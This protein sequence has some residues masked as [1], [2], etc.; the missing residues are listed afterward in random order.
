MEE[1]NS[2][3]SLT[4]PEWTAR[5][6]I[7]E[8]RTLQ[9][10]YPLLITYIKYCVG[11]RIVTLLDPM[12]NLGQS[13][14]RGASCLL[15]LFLHSSSSSTQIWEAPSRIKRP[16]PCMISAVK[17]FGIGSHYA[18]GLHQR[19]HLNSYTLRVRLQDSVSC[20]G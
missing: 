15:K 2:S 6:Y 5:C 13:S 17:V 3:E 16:S 9:I 4:D 8:Y 1:T 19:P 11:E 18:T 10:L 12:Q 20:Q 7:P 14:C